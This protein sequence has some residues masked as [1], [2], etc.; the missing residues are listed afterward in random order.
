M[1]SSQSKIKDLS[2]VLRNLYD[3]QTFSRGFKSFEVKTFRYSCPIVLAGE[4]SYP[5]SESALI[6]RSAICYISKE[7]R[8]K[9]NTEAMEW[10]EDNKELL[11]IRNGDSVKRIHKISAPNACFY[12]L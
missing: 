8:T 1:F 12:L 4:E 5:N 10:L 9:K 6:N 7:E 3:R 11:N 2:G